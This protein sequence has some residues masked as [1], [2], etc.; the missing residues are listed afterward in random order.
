MR[1]VQEEPDHW[2]Y[3]NSDIANKTVWVTDP[4]IRVE[5]VDLPATNGAVAAGGGE[6]GA[7]QPEGLTC[8]L[9]TGAG[10]CLGPLEAPLR[11]FLPANGQ[12]FL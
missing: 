7:P 11:A 2:Q 5:A 9:Q 6:G 10:W 4:D 8:T 1:R 3:W 12:A